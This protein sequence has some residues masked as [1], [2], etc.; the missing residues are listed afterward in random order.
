MASSLSRFC[1]EMAFK[2]P[3]A[4]KISTMTPCAAQAR[5]RACGQVR[6]GAKKSARRNDHQDPRRS[7]QI[8]NGIIFQRHYIQRQLG[9]AGHTLAAVEVAGCYAPGGRYPLP[10]SVIM[11]AV[12]ASVS[13]GHQMEKGTLQTHLLASRQSHL[14]ASNPI[15]QIIQ[16]QSTQP[17]EQQSISRSIDQSNHFP[18]NQ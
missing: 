9:E 8:A 2:T 14:I 16:S 11:T 3:H 4:A 7:V 13:V 10:S 12:E 15:N 6:G 18:I 17:T 1:S 5:R